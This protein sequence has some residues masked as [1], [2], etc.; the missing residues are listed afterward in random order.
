M[1]S[2]GKKPKSWELNYPALAF[3]LNGSYYADY[4]GVMG[5]MGLPTMH[6]STWDK[7]VSCLGIH[8]ERLAEWSCEQVRA[9][10]DKRGDRNQWAASFDG[11]YL[12]R[13]H[14]S[15][16]SSATVH[17]MESDRIAWFTHRTKRGKNSNWLGT[18]AGAE[19][20]MLNDL[21]GKVK[22]AKFCMSQIVM[23]HDTSANAIVCSHFPDIDIAYCGNH[24]SKSFYY[25]LCKIKDLKCKCKTQAKP[26]K[27]MTEAF[28]NRANCALRNLMS[29]E[30]ILQHEDPYKAFSE[31]LLN[32][33]NHYCLD[34]HGS[35]WCKFHPATTDDDKP[36]ATKS[37][38]LCAIHADAFLDLLKTMADKPQEYIT[39]TSKVTTNAVEGFH[40]LALK[41]RGKRIDLGHAH[42]CCKT[43]MAVCHKNLG[44]IW[45]LICLCEMG[46]DVPEEAVSAILDEQSTWEYY[47]QRRN[48][49]VYYHYRSLRKQRGVVGEK[50]HMIQLCA[51]GSTTAE[52][53]GSSSSTAEATESATL[54]DGHMSDDDYEPS[55]VDG[56]S[57]DV[58]GLLEDDEEDDTV[59]KVPLMFFFDL[60]STGGSMYTD[61]IM[62][63]AAKVVGVPN[64]VD[65][66][67]R[68]YSSLVHTSRDICAVVKRKVGLTNAMLKGQPP[69]PAV[70]EELLSWIG[71]TLDEVDQ[72]Q[73]VKHYP[74]LVAHNGFAF[75]YM[76]V[77]SE[78]QRR[79]M[80]CS[81]L[82]AIN[83]HFAD[84]LYDC[85]L[86]AKSEEKN[87][88]SAYTKTELKRLGIENLY[89]KYYP[90]ET[91]NAHRAL[92]DIL[93]MEKLF[94]TTPLASMLSLSTLA[95]RSI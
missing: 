94:T 45:K 36:Y 82:R 10:I 17:D 15:N 83:L 5:T 88:F 30:E 19:G 13:G 21:L 42:Y 79:D 93:A 16:N 68:H 33:H 52:Y 73:G 40:G 75:D 77:I 22:A 48:K 74:L 60:E 28:I 63:M 66:T 87:M 18:S 38:L 89:T 44:P 25:D 69:F 67:Q 80:S 86:L 8:V 37:P 32:F 84:T 24:T 54:D 9:D 27:R 85:R 92:A 59:D 7:L 29:C 31:G 51:V 61:H 91:Y 2:S 53:I 95:I 46:A 64:S 78:L 20:D 62:E 11:F 3:L 76:M 50:D 57:E 71:D 72:W 49:S 56:G 58:E 1:Q 81:S 26:C 55:D 39:P 70:L 14:H 6:H 35:E 4:A 65:I 23:D 41:Y 90:G 47:R 12:M 34:L 43:N